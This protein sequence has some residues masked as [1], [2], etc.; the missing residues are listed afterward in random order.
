MICGVLFSISTVVDHIMTPNFFHVAFFYS[1]LIIQLFCNCFY[2]S[3]V[4]AA[5]WERSWKKENSFL[6]RSTEQ[7]HGNEK[8]ER[9][10]VSGQCFRFFFPIQNSYFS[11]TILLVP[12]IS[13][14]SK[15]FQ[16]HSIRASILKF[17]FQ[18]E[19]I[20]KHVYFSSW[21]ESGKY[22]TRLRT[23]LSMI[24][25]R[26]KRQCRLTAGKFAM[27]DLPTFAAVCYWIST[28]QIDFVFQLHALEFTEEKLFN[29]FSKLR[30]KLQ[31]RNAKKYYYVICLN[32]RF[33][34]A[35]V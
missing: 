25:M 29:W 23:A 22:T 11:H 7:D 33:L 31:F 15:H 9:R 13:N 16:W 30:Q 17:K 6:L 34:F 32:G 3:Q 14:I 27:V 2:G 26:S 10:K 28:K 35:L 20:H 4:F 24:M 18:S 8:E 19:N 1:G 21:E 5:V 12:Y